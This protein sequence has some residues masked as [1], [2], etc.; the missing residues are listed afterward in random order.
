[1]VG[2]QRMLSAA[3][4]CMTQKDVHQHAGSGDPGAGG[5][6][7]GNDEPRPGSPVSLIPTD[8]PGPALSARLET[9]LASPGGLAVTAEIGVDPSAV[10]LLAGVSVWATFRTPAGA[11][12]LLAALARPTTVDEER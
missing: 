4:G 8:Q 6:P 7:F 5:S 9:W 3:G 11:Q 10:D 12:L 2:S 1:M